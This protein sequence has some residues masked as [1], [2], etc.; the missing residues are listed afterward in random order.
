M[1]PETEK[2]TQKHALWYLTMREKSKATTKSWFSRL[3]Q[4]PARK[5]SG[6]VLGRK[7]HTYIYLLTFP[8]PTH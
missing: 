1:H 4:H 5:R 8:A 3:L 6:S 7:T 2:I